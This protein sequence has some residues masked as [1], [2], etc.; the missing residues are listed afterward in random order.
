MAVDKRTGDRI[1]FSAVLENRGTGSG[2]VNVFAALGV[3]NVLKQWTTQPGTEVTK[4]V[5][6]APGERVRITLE[7][8]VPSSVLLPQKGYGA[9]YWLTDLAGSE[10]AHKVIG[11]AVTIKARPKADIVFTDSISVS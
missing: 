7:Y 8:Y 5:T 11:E 3:E 9:R 4:L 10:F 6:L 1:L 2:S